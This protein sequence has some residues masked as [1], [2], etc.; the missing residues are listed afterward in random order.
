MGVNASSLPRNP[1]SPIPLTRPKLDD[2]PE[3]CI[4]LVLS[5]MDP[6]VIAKLAR[7]NR[8]FRA[9]SSADFIWVPKLPST[10]PYILA[11]LPDQGNGNMDIYARLCRPN[12]FDGGTK[13]VWIDK[14]TGG[15]CLSISSKA[16]GIT[17]IDDRR[18]WNYIPTDESRFQT[19]AYLQQIWWL[20][21][22]G[23][24][25]FKFP[26]GTYSLF[27]RLQLGKVGK[28][29]GRRRVSNSEN[30]HGW[31]LKPAHFKLT[32]ADG[33]H[34]VSQCMLGNLGNWVHY[35][36]GDF[37]VEDDSILTKIKFSLTQI[38]CTHTKG[39]LCVDSVLICPI[40]LGKELVSVDGEVC[41]KL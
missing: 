14:M 3:S 12:P 41:K 25:E 11:K 15:V 21:V 22:D 23:E 4:A 37:V 10:Y 17:G 28:R 39:G 34:I 7:L 32:M 13:E 16:M 20:E 40:S 33:Q 35:H 38:D 31:D 9:A 2:I 30:V 36:V 26:K 8:A 29:M 1:N 24:L 19:V 27:F 5:Y 18:Y 6:P